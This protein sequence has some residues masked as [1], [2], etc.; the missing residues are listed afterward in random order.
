MLYPARTAST[1]HF[2]PKG[3]T[4]LQRQENPHAG[5]ISASVTRGQAA[6]CTAHPWAALFSGEVG[7]K[8]HQAAAG[9]G[10]FHGFV[11]VDLLRSSDTTAFKPELPPVL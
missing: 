7:A 4:D 11:D 5:S 2:A 3:P 6:L 9:R 10:V 1:R 8:V